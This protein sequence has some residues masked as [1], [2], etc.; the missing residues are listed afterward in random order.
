MQNDLL[1]T[2]RHKEPVATAR[3]S[4]CWTEPYVSAHFLKEPVSTSTLR[5]WYIYICLCCQHFHGPLSNHGSDF[6]RIT[7]KSSASI[8]EQHFMWS[9]YKSKEA[10]LCYYYAAILYIK[11]WNWSSLNLGYGN[12]E[13]AISNASHDYKWDLRHIIYKGTCS[14]CALLASTSDLFSM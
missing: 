4:I 8:T 13:S 12:E 11:L 2:S 5:T 6:K 14:A 3:L 1:P 9:I 10:N 7:W